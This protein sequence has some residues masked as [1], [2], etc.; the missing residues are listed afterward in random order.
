MGVYDPTGSG[1]AHTTQIISGGKRGGKVAKGMGF[2]AAAAAVKAKSGVSQQAA[3]AIIAA[4]ARNASPAAKKKNPNLKKVLPKKKSMGEV[5]LSETKAGKAPQAG[6]SSMKK[7]VRTGR[8]TGRTAGGKPT[9]RQVGSA[10]I[11][12]ARGARK[13]RG[14]LAPPAKGS[15][16]PGGY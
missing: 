4:G 5:D 11:A 9:K 7:P 16:N 14:T 12:E 3:N 13:S 8:A 1:N 10:A 2:K 6:S 15:A